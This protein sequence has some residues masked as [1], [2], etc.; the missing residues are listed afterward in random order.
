MSGRH[1]Q[2]PGRIRDLKFHPFYCSDTRMIKDGYDVLSRILRYGQQ[3]A[4]TLRPG[5]FGV[6]IV[7]TLEIQQALER[8]A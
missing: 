5:S 4:R 7:A 6:M 8:A 3:Y 1:V 2:V